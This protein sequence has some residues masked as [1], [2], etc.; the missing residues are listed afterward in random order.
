MQDSRG[1]EL[2]TRSE[3]AASACSAGSDGYV[4]FRQTAPSD[5]EAASAADPDFALPLIIRGWM[6]HSARSLRFAPK[7][8]EL[9]SAAEDRLNQEDRR[10]RALLQALKSARS[11]DAITAASTLETL[12]DHYPTDLLAHRLV[13]FELFWNGR[14]GWMRDIA[15]RAAPHW[16]SGLSGFSA[17]QSI[18]GFSNAECGQYDI[19]ERCGREAIEIDPTDPWG[20]HAVTHVLFM[21]GR[22]DEGMDWLQGLSGNWQ[23]VTQFRH[24]LW[25][26]LALF[27][28]ERGDTERALELVE[29]EIRNPDSPLVRNVPDA[30][31]DIQNVA[32]LLLRLELMGVDVGSRWS[33][34][35]EICASR[36]ADHSSAFTSAH[37]M[38]VLAATGQFDLAQDLLDNL[39]DYAATSTGSLAT[40]YGAAGIAACEA[41]LAHRRGDHAS[42]LS[43]LSPVRHDL[44]L[45]GASHAQRDVFFQILL[46]SAAK[47]GRNDLVRLYLRDMARLGFEHVSERSVYGA[48]EGSQGSP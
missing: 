26:H 17:F 13:Q 11:G 6:L 23:E 7:I 10:E 34:L 2:S 8:V 20:A 27:V 37:D 14:T 39:R 44:S 46:N 35:A 5:L 1:H 48:I 28:L 41:I 9:M 32:S 16:H 24:H 36:V 25:W 30:G 18:R 4:R 15:D 29:S 33:V 45:V 40:A 19:A 3:A 12:L 42:V 22:T 43:H 38:M 21:Q 47:Q 31:T